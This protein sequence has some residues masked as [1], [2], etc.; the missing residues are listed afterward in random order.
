MCSTANSSE[1]YLDFFPSLFGLHFVLPNATATQSSRPCSTN[2]ALASISPSPPDSRWR[3]SE[4]AALVAEGGA[5]RSW[6][7]QRRAAHRGRNPVGG[8]GLSR[9]EAAQSHG[10]GTRPRD[11]VAV[12]GLMATAPPLD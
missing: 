8:V 1:G 10:G 4:I 9:E 5:R 6:P 2:L 7:W 12:P 11:A 3:H